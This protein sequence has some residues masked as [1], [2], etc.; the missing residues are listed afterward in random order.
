MIAKLVIMFSIEGLF[1]IFFAI[2]FFRRRAMFKKIPVLTRE[3]PDLTPA[4]FFG[5]EDCAPGHSWGPCIRKYWLLH[6]V[7]R[8]FGFLD[9]G[10]K[11]F[12]IG[13]GDLF[14]VP[15]DTVSTYWADDKHPWE[16]IF[17]EFRPHGELPEFMHQSVI[18]C[19]QVGPVFERMKECEKF[20]GGRAAFLTGCLWEM[21]ALLQEQNS[22]SIG[23][24]DQA[25]RWIRSEYMEGLTVQECADRLHLSRCYFSTQF[26]KKTGDSPQQYLINVR[27]ERAA[28]LLH[29]EG[30]SP[31]IAAA[32]VGYGDIY[33]FSKAF[34]KHFGLSPR[35]YQ[36]KRHTN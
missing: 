6:Y 26:K 30:I 24:I 13:P 15:A 16:Y 20:S 17:L 21:M 29:K 25:I 8:G 12:S 14:I 9:W 33:Q 2:L 28:V 32:S 18:H 35:E 7:V 19:P 23:E 1:L 10:G 31:S 36:K 4:A 27:M 5:W 3:I 11:I 34:K 22:P